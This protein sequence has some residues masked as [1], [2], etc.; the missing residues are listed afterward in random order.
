MTGGNDSYSDSSSKCF[1]IIG[2]ESGKFCTDHEDTGSK[3]C[4]GSMENCVSKG[5]DYCWRDPD[6]FGIMY[7]PKWSENHKV[8]IC[9]SS[10]L[11]QKAEKDWTV[12]MK[13]S[14]SKFK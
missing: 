8:K 3:F 14:K 5:E 13:C 7:H 4:D 9:L 11:E 10:T 12:Y 2:P 6:C 1:S